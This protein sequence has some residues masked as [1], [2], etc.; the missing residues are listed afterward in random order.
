MM[1][2]TGNFNANLEKTKLLIQNELPNWD[3]SGGADWE[4]LKALI[5]EYVMSFTKK[6]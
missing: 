5:T 6:G 1:N 3:E 4:K 2:L